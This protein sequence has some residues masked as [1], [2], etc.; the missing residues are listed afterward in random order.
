M[1]NAH[2]HQ[3]DKRNG[4]SGPALSLTEKNHTFQLSLLKNVLKH[5][6]QVLGFRFELEFH[7]ATERRISKGAKHEDF[8][9]HGNISSSTYTEY[10]TPFKLLTHWNFQETV[11]HANV[12]FNV[13]HHTFKPR[14]LDVEKFSLRW[15]Y[16]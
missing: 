9:F 12:D 2:I 11:S 4:H 14:S 3:N 5:I 13:L 6:L 16:E 15:I 1:S 7:L 8:R 10:E